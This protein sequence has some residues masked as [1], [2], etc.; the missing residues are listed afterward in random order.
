M[1]INS[2]VIIWTCVTVAVLV[3]ICAIVLIAMSSRNMKKNREAMRDLQGAIKVG[4]RIMFAGGIYGK[5]VKIKNDVI[6]VE[7]NKSTVKIFFKQPRKVVDRAETESVCDLADCVLILADQLFT[8]LKF[9][10]EQIVLW[11]GVQVSLEQRLQ[12]R[13]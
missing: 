4:A 7:I 5:I 3:G 1:A 8:F 13:T 6:D 10:I 12:R 9:N 2:E 11:R